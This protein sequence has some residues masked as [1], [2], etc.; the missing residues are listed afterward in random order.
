MKLPLSPEDL[1][2]GFDDFLSAS[3]RTPPVAVSESVRRRISAKLHPSELQVFARLSLIHLVSGTLTLLL[4]P[5]F[6][7]SLT[8]HSVNLMHFF[9]RLG[10]HACAFCCGAF[11]LGVSGFVA[12]VLLEPEEVQVLR[13]SRLLQLSALALGS[14]GV[15]ICLTGALVPVDY[16]L[17]WL[18]GSVFSSV[19]S[20]ELGSRLRFRGNFGHLR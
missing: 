5:Q 10:S 18:C 19:G 13:S 6:G 17:V 8:S 11:F 14:L 9:M 16:A 2:K 15:F 3:P 4:C 7:M 12:G 20:V 1:A